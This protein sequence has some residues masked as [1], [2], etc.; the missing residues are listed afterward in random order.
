LEAVAE[1]RIKRGDIPMLIPCNSE[2]Q[3]KMLIEDKTAKLKKSAES[4]SSI[5]PYFT[6]QIARKKMTQMKV[7]KAFML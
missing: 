1:K 4:F 6:T 7:Y 3:E 2:S 5:R